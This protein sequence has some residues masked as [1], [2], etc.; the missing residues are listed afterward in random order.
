[1]LLEIMILNT[2]NNTELNRK[3]LRDQKTI[4]EIIAEAYNY[5]K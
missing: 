3:I 2:V 1:M 4:A 5:E